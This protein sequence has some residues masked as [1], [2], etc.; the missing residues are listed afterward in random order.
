M[1]RN[2]IITRLLAFSG[3]IALV[4]VLGGCGDTKYDSGNAST[5]PPT[6]TTAEAAIK[7]SVDDYFNSANEYY[8]KVAG[9]PVPGTIVGVKLSGYQPIYYATGCAEIDLNSQ[10]AFKAPACKTPMTTDMQFRIAS[11]T[12][13]FVAD[14]VVKLIREGKLSYD[15]T[16]ESILPGALSGLNE[17]YKN[18]IT[19]KQ[20]LDHTSGLYTYVTT[21][22]GL[23]NGIAANP[24]LPMN[25]FVMNPGKN[26]VHSSSPQDDVLKFVNTFN[27]YSSNM[28]LMGE[29]KDIKNLP[30]GTNPYFAPGADWHYSNSNYYLLGLIIEKVTGKTVDAEIKRLIAD[31]LGMKDTYLPTTATFNTSKFVHGYTDYLDMTLSNNRFDYAILKFHSN[32]SPGPLLGAPYIAGDGILE[33]FSSVDP[34]FA[35]ASGGMISSAKDMLVFL[36]HVINTR[37]KT[38]DETAYWIMGSPMMGM[39]FEYGRGLVKIGGMNFGHGGQFAGYNIAAYWVAPL[40]AYVLVMTNKYS[41]HEDDPSTQTQGISGIS[42]KILYKSSLYLSAPVEKDLNT[43]LINAIISTLANQPAATGK[44]VGKSVDS[45]LIP[46]ISSRLR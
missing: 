29:K 35:W 30:Y 12:K 22:A 24:D 21:D 44:I 20:L 1:Q 23:T 17:S 36:E 31:P 43:G 33:D 45:L 5:P 39:T 13:M 18:T 27:P 40:D 42:D 14:A 3:C 15:A 2:K 10:V 4:T 19:I 38:R 16:V 9:A 7:K 25:K 32:P 46:D 6:K 28:K 11:V 34:S 41:Y 26:W 8:I 37:V